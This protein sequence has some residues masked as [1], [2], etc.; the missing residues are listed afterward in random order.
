MIITYKHYK[1]LEKSNNACLTGT[2]S[3]NNKEYLTVERFDKKRID[4]ILIDNRVPVF[5][6]GRS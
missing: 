3:K 4:H 6:G 1:K 2:V 5:L